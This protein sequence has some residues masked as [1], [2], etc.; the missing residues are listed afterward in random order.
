MIITEEIIDRLLEAEIANLL[1]RLE[2]YAARP[3]NPA[4]VYIRRFGRA[5]AF[6]AEKIESRFFNSVLG[7][8]PEHA[9]E[10]DELLAYYHAHGTKP[11]MEIAPG[12][13]TEPFALLLSERG[14]AMVEYHVGLAR[15]LTPADASLIGSPLVEIELVDPLDS[16]RFDRLIEV[17]LQGWGTKREAYEE[18][19]V[20]MRTWRA[21]KEW[22]FY[23]AKVAG[24]PAGSAVLDRRGKTAML[25]SAS[26]L[27]AARG[28]GV[29]NALITRRIADAAALG[30]DLLISGAN[31]GTSSMRNQQRAGFATICTKGVWI[32]LP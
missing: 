32:E 27:P 22:T 11:A 6:C 24:A 18:A 20:N 10:L 1:S 15:V 30:C 5:V 21:N 26:T 12:R 14:F 3:G 13:L 8:G 16:E 17:N 7:V 19:K 25:G 23:L 2:P 31:Y 28:R 9:D 29:Q 4:G